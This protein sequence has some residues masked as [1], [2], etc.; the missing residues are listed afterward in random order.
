MRGLFN[1]KFNLESWGTAN[2]ENRIGSAYPPTMSAS[3]P[4]ELEHVVGWTGRYPG[5]LH[6][7]PVDD[8]TYL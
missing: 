3:D 2:G 1:L 6:T 7:H 5:T 8:S 4:L